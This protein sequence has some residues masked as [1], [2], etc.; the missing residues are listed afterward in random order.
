MDENQNQNKEIAMLKEIAAFQ[1]NTTISDQILS[2][3]KK[4]LDDQKKKESFTA[5]STKRNQ[6]SAPEKPSHHRNKR[7][8]RL[9]PVNKPKDE[10]SN[11]ANRKFYGPPTN[12]SDLSQLGYTLNG[13]YL[14]KAPESKSN[15]L[16][17]GDKIQ[18]EAISCTFKHPEGIY[19]P[20]NVIEKKA[21]VP[22][23]NRKLF[24][25]ANNSGIHF[26]VRLTSNVEATKSTNILF[27]H[28]TLN[29]GGGS[30]NAKTGHFT[31]PKTGIYQI[32]FTGLIRGPSATQLSDL[33][34]LFVMVNNGHLNWAEGNKIIDSQYSNQVLLATMKLRQGHNI[35][36]FIQLFGDGKKVE[37]KRTASFSCSLLE[38]IDHY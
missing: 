8:Y 3:I 35:S 12:C 34:Y 2:L 9:I 30:Y 36:I 20:F 4:E 38:L 15:T 26:R 22:Y 33:T 16:K 27:D 10:N 7:P 25:A 37:L 31:I 1:N 24:N 18:V 23:L 14:V 29:Y 19:Q 5:K 13:F 28:I 17:D 21:S 32:T 11:Q 6:D